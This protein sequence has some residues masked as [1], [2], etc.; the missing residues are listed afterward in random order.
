MDI[1]ALFV[2]IN[3]SNDD[4]EINLIILNWVTKNIFM[5][6]FKKDFKINY[7]NI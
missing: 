3:F 5:D 4:N 6:I 7:K 1:Q 2:N